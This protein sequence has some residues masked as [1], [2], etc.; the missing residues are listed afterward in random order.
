VSR[1]INSSSKVRGIVHR[2]Y[3]VGMPH[4]LVTKNKVSCLHAPL[5]PC[6]DVRGNGFAIARDFGFEME[7]HI[8]GR[9]TTTDFKALGE[10]DGQKQK[11]VFSASLCRVLPLKGLG[12]GA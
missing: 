10:A 8:V 11:R 5:H 2:I 1:Y 12:A 9:G 4:E 7:R 3:K 6:P